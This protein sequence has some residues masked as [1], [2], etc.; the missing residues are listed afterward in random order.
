MRREAPFDSD[1]EGAFFVWV[2]GPLFA[3]AFPAGRTQRKG[4]LL[5]TPRLLSLNQ[6]TGLFGGGRWNLTRSSTPALSSP[7]VPVLSGRDFTDHGTRVVRGVSRT[8]CEVADGLLSRGVMV[9]ARQVG[10]VARPTF[11]VVFEPRRNTRPHSLGGRLDRSRRPTFIRVTLRTAQS[12]TFE[13]RRISAVRGL[14]EPHART[15]GR[16][17]LR[18]TS[19]R[20]RYHCDPT[21]TVF[22][23]GRRTTRIGAVVDR[24]GLV[25]HRCGRAE[26]TA[27]I[28]IQRGCEREEPTRLE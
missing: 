6:A 9:V 28:P 21:T 5:T 27:A 17:Q 20:A 19:A 24:G 10:D 23:A 16:C 1:V 15:L 12:E 25:R 3:M 4:T 2:R 26:S 14:F 18:L 8:A 11:R 13:S 7:A 22:P